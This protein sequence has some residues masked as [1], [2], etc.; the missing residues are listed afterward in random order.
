MQRARIIYNPSSGREL[1]KRNV[2]HILDRLEGAGYE[3]SCH[4]TK[5][6]ADAT[7]A[8]KA[9]AER[10]FDLVVA[11]GGDGT[12]YEVVNGLAPLQ[13]RPTLGIIPAGTTNDFARA[14][15]IPK[16][17]DK[18]C[19]ILIRGHKKEI[20]IGKV[21]D[22][23]FINIAGGGTLTELTYEVPSKL[24]TVLGQLA[25]YMKGI[26][27]L[28]HL[29][30][31]RMKIESREKSIDDEIMMFLVANSHSIGGFERLTPKADLQDG[32]FDVLVVKKTST[33]EFIK[34]AT[35]AVRGEHLDDERVIY[36]QTAELQVT[37]DNLVQLN[38]D[39]ELGGQLPGHF[40]VMHKHLSILTPH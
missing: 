25:Y 19:E 32:Y 36:F 24:K 37:S 14:L 9:A 2:L 21:N 31:A 20:D 8:A 26:E 3:T 7:H 13:T 15:G 22:Q 29:K 1:I 16:D 18:A 40:K 33:P 5:G 11:A 4:A 23:Y 39:G 34:L 30:P 35:H 27:K 6:K 10:G 28:V 12:L 38:L 17:I